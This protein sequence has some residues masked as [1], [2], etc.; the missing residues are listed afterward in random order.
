MEGSAVQLARTLLLLFV[1]RQD[2]S[3]LAGRLH[4]DKVLAYFY[5]TSE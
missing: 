3:V 5:D 2:G 4:V 1:I